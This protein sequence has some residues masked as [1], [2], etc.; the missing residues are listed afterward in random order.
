MCVLSGHHVTQSVSVFS[1]TPDGNWSKS[2]G[3]LVS[4]EI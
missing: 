2:V 1:F 4:F 3:G